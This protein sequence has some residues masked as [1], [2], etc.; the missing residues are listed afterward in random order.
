MSKARQW[1]QAK[2]EEVGATWKG[3][4][5]LTE[6]EW[7]LLMEEYAQSK[8]VSDEEIDL[9]ELFKKETNLEL[10]SEYSEFTGEQSGD[11]SNHYVKWLENKINPIKEQ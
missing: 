4:R 8:P 11:F 6:F 5:N 7:Y 1:I 10:M 9:K 2:A 3:T